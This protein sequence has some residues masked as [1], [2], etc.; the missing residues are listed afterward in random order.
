[1]S[2]LTSNKL[3]VS[4]CLKLKSVF[5]PFYRVQT[6]P[7]WQTYHLPKVLPSQDATFKK[8]H[9]IVLN[10]LLFEESVAIHQIRIG[11]TP[12]NFDLKIYLVL[13]NSSI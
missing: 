5:K 7:V 8:R 10:S 13:P 3:Y 12:S 9:S 11:F 1:M 2:F 4:V 6:L